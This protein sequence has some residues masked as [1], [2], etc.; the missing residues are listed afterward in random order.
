MISNRSKW[1]DTM[2]MPLKSEFMF[3]LHLEIVAPISFFKSTSFSFSLSP[4]WC[5]V[6]TV[7]IISF[8]CFFFLVLLVSLN[9]SLGTIIC[10]SINQWM[11]CFLAHI[12]W[13]AVSIKSSQFCDF[14]LIWFDHF[15]RDRASTATSYR[16]WANFAFTK[17]KSLVL[18]RIKR[19]NT[20][21]R[22]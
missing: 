14:L 15:I 12:I 8:N 3:L 1:R 11:T 7:E 22:T 20:H 13:T 6:K 5:H 9:H 18:S 2:R 21:A 17:V 16:D 10:C 4:N 19:D